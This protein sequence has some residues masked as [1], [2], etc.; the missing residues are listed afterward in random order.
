M[1]LILVKMFATAL[2]LAQV[3][4]RPDSL[5]IEFDPV[6]DQAEVVQLLKDGCAHMRKAFDIEDL[7]LDVLIDTAMSDPQTVAGEIRAF[8]GINFDEL[9]IAY[10]QFCGNG[11]V[12]NSPFDMKP[13]IEFYNGV[14]AN[15][16]DH[17]RL[18]NLKLPGTS[19]VMDI[20]GE[21][22]AE[23]FESD[24]RRTWVPLR[25]IPEY[26]QLAFVAAEDKRFYQ[27][28]GID[29]RGLIRAFIT[30]IAEPGR[31]QGGST[32][33]QQVAKNLLVGD[34]VS[35]ERKIREM[36]VASRIDQ[37]L[38][39]DEILEIY[40]NSIYLGRGAWGIDMAAHGY[41]KK[42][43][44]VL[45][46]TEGAMLAAMAKGPSYFSPDRYPERA[47]ERYAYVLKR[48]QEDKVAGTENVTPGV[49]GGP[50]IV[51]YDKPKR[52]GGFHFVDHLMREAKTLV[53][54]ASLTSESFT[55]RSTINSKLQ[56]ATEQALQDGLAR[57]EAKSGRAVY[58]GPELSL[59]DMVHRITTE[60]STRALR[61]GRVMKP[62]WQIALQTAKLPLYDVHWPIAVVLGRSMEHGRSQI[63]VGLRDGRIVPLSLPEGVSPEMLK[64]ND[65]IFVNV[66]EGKKQSEA[67][68][69]LRIKPKVQGAAL[70]LENKSGR[71]LAMV[72]GFSYPLSQLNRTT[73]ALR[74]PGSS[75]KPLTYLAAL[76]RGLQPN[77]LVIDQA[78]TLPPIPGVST[79]YWTPKNYD[80]HSAGTM[81]LRRA[82]EQSKNLV[83]TRLLDGGIDKDPTRSLEQICALALEAKIYPECMKNYPFILG[84]QALRMIDLAGFY[85]AIANEGQR[86]IPYTIDAI[87]KNGQAVYRHDAGRPV[88]MA[89]GDR[90]AFFQ[91]RTILEGVVTRGTA[92][93]MKHL[94]GFAGGK[95]GT[96][97]NENDAW[98]GGF[99]SDVTVV[100]WVGYDN[101]RGKQTLGRGGTGGQVAVPIVEQ[102]M[103]AAWNFQSPKAPLPPPS[104][105]A[106]RTLKAMPIDLNSG[107]RLAS[108]KNG[109]FTEY[110]RLDANKKLRDT[111]YAL[112]GRHSLARSGPMPAPAMNDDRSPQPHPG[113]IQRP[114]PMDRIPRTLRELFR[115]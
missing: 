19:T 96:T 62:I 69:E 63:R 32:I 16:P 13:V 48:M 92:A 82:L 24:H 47:R 99:T 95:T 115:L 111:H 67:K 2:A 54:M 11:Q 100:V 56:R 28:K 41:F 93:S 10:K 108:A 14:A 58:Q 18:K 75:I 46:V 114:N 85:A 55:V 8:R 74:Q 27:H 33:T 12:E 109:G 112:A 37:A 106:A 79:H 107:Q 21:K 20:K 30:N 15:L 113:V 42:P 76:H 80:G 77:T 71:I 35:Y 36:I 59:G 23:L 89:G 66:V 26:V 90:A 84:A 101:A 52:E 51:P 4:T 44:A 43:A 17:N 103:Q 78:V 70:V 110:F 64:L 5:K 68:A 61:R 6:N 31:P 94:S 81:T 39:K 34:D 97:D 45:T 38:S 86:V 3:T 72:G 73:Q 60:Q 25:Q 104:A 49:T 9:A 29:E 87:E 91:L 50:R 105:E 1:N 40:L 102:I 88:I 22:F 7:N 57:Y 83:T 98:F 65:V 53:G